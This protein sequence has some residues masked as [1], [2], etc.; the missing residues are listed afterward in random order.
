MKKFIV[1]QAKQ[2]KGKVRVP[3]DKSISHRAVM[4]GSLA[5]GDSKI[6]GFLKADDCMRTI[7]SFRKMGIEINIEDDI[8]IVKGK[9][10]MGLHEP[11]DVFDV[12]NSGTTM[13]LLV[14]ILAGQKFHTILTGDES[15]RRR[16]MG[17]VIE[18]LKKM[19]AIIH[20]RQR[21]TL[22][23]LTIM[24]K[25]LK[26][27]TYGMPVASAQVKSAVLLAGLYAKGET[28][29]IEKELTRDHTE[30]MLEYFG[31]A[32]KREDKR[33][34]VKGGVEFSGKKIFVPGDISSASF[35]MVAALI[36]PGSDIIIKDVGVNPGRTGIIDVLHR[37]GAN[38]EVTNERILSN[39]PV[40]DIS[41]R[42]S[43]LNAVELSGSIIPRIIDEIPIIAVAATQAKGKTVI[44]NAEELH[45][46]ESDRIKTTV[47]ELRR[48]GANIEE[49]RDGMVIYGPTKLKK[50]ICQSYGDHRIAMIS[51]I[52]GLAASDQTV[53]EK[54]EC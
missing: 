40:A 36:V 54:V 31:A 19:G 30:R 35:L 10:L 41:I 13:R 47:H 14:G 50:G 18:P 53:V 3:G 43:D 9:G 38:I 33:I 24:G 8:V 39:E 6:E 11:S 46:K 7:E 12:G 32:I 52:A 49:L 26:G 1:L 20:G 2:L 34:S 15:I 44:K 45:L 4:I 25:E 21:D 5:K 16:P 51:S 23:P 48:L 22:A 37:M 17:R 29:V 42:S 28:S 27:I